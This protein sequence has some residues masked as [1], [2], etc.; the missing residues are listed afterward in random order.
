MRRSPA[1]GSWIATTEG[2]GREERA[3]DAP[4]RGSSTSSRRKKFASRRTSRV[5]VAV[6][7]SEHPLSREVPSHVGVTIGRVG[8]TR[9]RCCITSALWPLPAVP[10]PPSS[11][12]ATTWPTLMFSH[13][14]SPRSLRPP[15]RGGRVAHRCSGSPDPVPDPAR[16]RRA[17]A[18]VRARDS[19]DRAPAGSRARRRSAAAPLRTAFF[20]SLREFRANLKS[21][22]LL[23]IGLVLLTMVLVAWAAH[24]L[25]QDLSWAGRSSSARSS[26]RPTRSPRPRSRSGWDCRA[27]SSD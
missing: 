25:I 5:C 19:G 26:R 24:E 4:Q 3:P 12:L 7:G 11:G 10:R 2:Q 14:D 18:R 27:G 13:E 15:R 6:E 9:R 16:P 17:G 8:S 23:A 21:I 20:T 22:A 1:S